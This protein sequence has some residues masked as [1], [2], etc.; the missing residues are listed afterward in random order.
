MASSRAT[1]PLGRGFDRWYGFHGGET[2]QF[3]PALYHDNHSVPSV[4]KEI[5]D[6]YHLT[7]DLTD[8]AIEFVGDLRAVD[9]DHPF[10]LYFA[11]GACH[12]PH[13]APREWIARY[14]GKFDQGWD[15]L[16]ERIHAR[17]MELGVVPDGTVLS[18]RPI[19][20]RPWVELSRP[21][22]ALAARFMECFAGFL[23]HTDAEIGRLVDFIENLGELDNTVIVV[24][25]DNGASSEGGSEGSINDIRLSNMDP[26]GLEEMQANIDDIGGPLTHN[27]CPWGRTMAGDTP[28][29]LP[30]RTSGEGYPVSR[31][32]PTF[33]S[34]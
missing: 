10:F 13:Q 17:Q 19:W 18:A 24:V 32:A 34:D 7:T 11:T 2:H 21:E 8:R 20:V 23:S 31:A 4:S 3:V 14:R 6:G 16:R 30:F 22:Q 12:S 25:S 29:K 5:E 28:F 1:W 33:R 27:N 9:A 26:A 15:E